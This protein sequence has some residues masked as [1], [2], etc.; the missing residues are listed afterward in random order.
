MG[1]IPRHGAAVLPLRAQAEQRGAGG[2]LRVA[3]ELSGHASGAFRAAR[4]TSFGGPALGEQAFFR[5][6]GAFRGEW[7]PKNNTRIPETCPYERLQEIVRG[8]AR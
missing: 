5:R 8:A 2:V 7:L 1:E 3:A 4:G 6:R